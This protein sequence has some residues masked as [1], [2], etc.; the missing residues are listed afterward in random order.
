MDLLA[1]Y[2][3]VQDKSQ[4]RDAIRE[5]LLTVPNAPD[6]FLNESRRIIK[7]LEWLGVFDEA[8]EF[9][10]NSTPID[11]LCSLLTSSLQFE[12]HERDMIL[13]QHELGVEWKDGKCEKLRSTLIAFGDASG[14]T[15]MAKTVGYPLGIAAELILNNKIQSRGVIGPVLPE[16]YEPLLKELK[17][18]GLTFVE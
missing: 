15:A 2:L 8:T 4:L 3:G 7:A 14:E 11:T 1:S 16:I 5:K 6:R 17:H 13:L 12:R 10:T 18:R 9:V